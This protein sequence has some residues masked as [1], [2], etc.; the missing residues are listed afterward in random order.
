MKTLTRLYST[1]ALLVSLAICAHAQTIYVA[2]GSN[3]SA[4]SL[5]TF[6][7]AT[8]S[9]LSAPV[10]I[11]NASGGG[12]IGITGLAFNPV[13]GDLFGVTVRDTSSGNTV[14][15]SLVKIDPATGVATVIG[16]LGFDTNQQP[17]AVGDISFSADGT[18][19][20]W[21]ARS[22]FS[23]A[24]INLTTGALSTVGPSAFTTTV[25]GGLAFSPVATPDGKAAGTLY[26]SATG[27]S[28]APSP[29]PSNNTRGTLDT[30]NRNTGAVTKGVTLSGAPNDFGPFPSQNGSINALAFDASGVLYGA[31]SDQFAPSSVD[32]VTI[33]LVT[34]AIID[35]FGLPNNTDAIAFKFEPVPEPSTVGLLIF[36]AVGS[37]GLLYY[38]RRRR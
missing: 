35:L 6:D 23:L 8:G 15:A 10:A 24:T 9:E 12:G 34:G 11:T 31:N 25:G 22:P 5:Y 38:R 26:L 32:L 19:Y 14:A 27:A 20:G 13:T 36:G 1:L 18:L 37:A 17:L 28:P 7:V 4:G 16:A 33:N 3:G 21:E 2:T 30:V 29:S